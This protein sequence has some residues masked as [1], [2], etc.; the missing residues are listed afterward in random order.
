MGSDVRSWTIGLPDEA[1]TMRF[2]AS[3]APYLRAGDVVGLTGELGSGKTTIARGIIRAL[4]G[5]EIEVPSPT[6]TLAQEYRDLVPPVMHYDLYR[7]RNSGELAEIGLGEVDRDALVLVEWP[8][9]AEGMIAQTL[10][11]DLVAAP[12]GRL[13]T[14][15]GDEVWSGWMRHARS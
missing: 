14:V 13:A 2:A 8:Q 4:A 9:R 11:I 1:A 6:F 5:A 12:Q 3:L 7:L 10:S 15:K